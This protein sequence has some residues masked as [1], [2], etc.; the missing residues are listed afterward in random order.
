MKEIDRGVI[1]LIGK[2]VNVSKKQVFLLLN[3]LLIYVIILIF[4]I[5]YRFT[6]P[7]ASLDNLV[8][9]HVPRFISS[10]PANGDKLLLD[11]FQAGFSMEP[12]AN[13]RNFC[14][15]FDISP[16]GVVSQ[17]GLE[18][19][20]NSEIPES[21]QISA[22]SFLDTVSLSINGKPISDFQL[23][24]ESGFLIDGNR[25]GNLFEENIIF[26]CFM[27]NLEIG[28]YFVELDSSYNYASQVSGTWT[29]E[30]VN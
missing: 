8:L 30:I 19:A 4:F 1:Y 15:F 29:F 9:A 13:S 27:L 7:P 11:D 2:G 3:V 20:S 6:L 17:S 5:H 10:D 26:T 14:V 23:S 18:V 25:R 24:E 22:S 21:A 16:I 28:N 12:L